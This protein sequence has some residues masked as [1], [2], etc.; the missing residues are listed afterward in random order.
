MLV[1]G[2][3]RLHCSF[4]QSDQKFLSLI[5]WFS[6]LCARSEGTSR[7]GVV[8]TLR[9]VALPL[10]ARRLNCSN[11]REK[12]GLHYRGIVH[13]WSCMRRRAHLA[14]SKSRVARPLRYL[15]NHAGSSLCKTSLGKKI[16]PSCSDVPVGGMTSFSWSDPKRYATNAHVNASS[17]SSRPK[18]G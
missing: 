2:V 8:M 12:E 1:G 17:M 11:G 5:H 13:H 18:G 9:H 10:T 15:D 7:A 4:S 3:V 14:G 6:F 16:H